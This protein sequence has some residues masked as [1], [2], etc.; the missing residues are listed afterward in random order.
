VSIY[1]V[2][3]GRNAPS[4]RCLWAGLLA[5]S[6]PGAPPEGKLHS[7]TLS[8]GG[9]ARQPKFRLDISAAGGIGKVV[10]NHPAG[11]KIQTLTCDLFRD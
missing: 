11:A 7:R 8:I 2:K 3:I 9:S 10:V 1:V 6:A 4:L 5:P